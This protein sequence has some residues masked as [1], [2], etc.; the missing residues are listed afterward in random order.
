VLGDHRG[1][2]GTIQT[3]RGEQVLVQGLVPFV[4]IEHGE[5]AGRR[6]GAPHDMHDDVDSTETLADG[7]GDDGAAVRSGDIR[8]D[9]LICMAD[10]FRP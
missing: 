10:L 8:G 7:L 5:P 6:R 9:E 2:Q 4:V 3:D 1:Y